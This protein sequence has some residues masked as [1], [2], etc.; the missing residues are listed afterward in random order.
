M[1]PHRSTAISRIIGAKKHASQ[2]PISLQ[3]CDHISTPNCSSSS[4]NAAD[5]ALSNIPAMHGPTPPSS[6]LAATTV[7]RRPFLRCAETHLFQVS[8]AS[9]HGDSRLQHRQLQVASRGVG[10]QRHR[11]SVRHWARAGLSVR[12]GRGQR[13]EEKVRAGLPACSKTGGRSGQVG[14]PV[15]CR[16]GQRGVSDSGQMKRNVYFK[17]IRFSTSTATTLLRGE[18]R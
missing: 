11:L 17:D 6:P 8:M 16:R 10:L 3:V 7:S 9:Q 18:N 1:R 5:A 12:C 14:L 4:N 2:E 15:R 13:V